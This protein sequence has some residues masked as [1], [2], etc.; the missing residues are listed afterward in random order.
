MLAMSASEHDATVALTSHLPQL[1]STALA[2]TLAKRDSPHLRNVFGGGL[3]DMTRLALSSPD[4]WVSIL[5]TNKMLVEDALDEF[6]HTLDGIRHAIGQDEL[7]DYFTR[8]SEYSA[9][10]RKL[11]LKN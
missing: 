8:A 11:P 10:L 2:D 5:G 9:A 4:L 7:R 3:L 6:I 1:L